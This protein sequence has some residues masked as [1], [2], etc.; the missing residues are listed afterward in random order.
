MP[1]FH[2]ISVPHS[3][4]L[5]KN[6][7]SEVYA[8]KLWDVHNKRGSDEYVDAETFFDKTYITDNMQDILESVKRRLDG[9][10]GGHFRSI[11]TP[12]GG[13]KTH[14][15][16]ALYH[17]C[18][19]W[20]SKPVVIV[21]NELDVRKQ[22]IWGAIEEQLTGKVERLGG[23]IPRGGEV[24]RSVLEEQNKPVLI[25]IDELL[26]YIVKAEG[27]KI[28]ETTLAIQTIAF[29]QELSEAVNSLEN[30]CVV[31][32][33]PSSANEQFDGERYEMLCDMLRKVAGRVRDTISPVADIDIPRIIRRRLFSSTDDE[34]RD[35]AEGIVKGHVN[36]CKDAGLIP[37]NMQPSEYRDAFLAS[38]P[39]LPQVIDVL[40]K[41]WGTLS[42][43]QRTRG[44][45][46]L[47]SLVVGSL[48]D[49]DKQFITLGDFDMSNNAI[50][51]EI[52]EYLSP[53][54][55]GVIAKDVV[56]DGSGAHKVDHKVP[57]QYQGKHLGTRAAAAMFMYSHSG[58]ADIKNGAT[59][60]E[61]KRA[62]CEW[63]IPAA[64]I[65]E[66]LNLFRSNMFYLNV[67][68]GRYMFTKETNMQKHK[69]DIMDNLQ[70]KD[71]EDATKDLLQKNIMRIR[72]ILTIL[73]PTKSSDVEDSKR[74]KLA[75]MREND[76]ELIKIIHDRYGE[77]VRIYRNNIFFL[78]PSDSERTRFMRSLKSKIALEKIK[79]DPQINLKDE[80]SEILKSELDNE[81]AHLESL[82]K[83]YYGVLYIPEENG[84]DRNMMR[85]PPVTNSGI[86]RMVYDQ[87][88][89]GET[90]STNIGPMSLRR[91]YLNDKNVVD[92][93]DLLKSMLSVPGERRPA[94]KD[95]LARAITNGVHT[96]EFGLG[97]VVNGTP[98][99]K[100][101]KEP[102]VVNF[103]HG[104]AII[105]ASLC[106]DNQRKSEKDIKTGIKENDAESPKQ[107]TP[108]PSTIKHH[109]DNNVE[110]L[111][112]GFNVPEGQV[113]HISRMLLSIASHYKDLRLQVS[114]SDGSMSEHDVKMIKETLK[115]MGSEFD[116]LS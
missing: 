105:H 93:S 79:I 101:F 66:V 8:A 81:N 85:P 15:L 113:N 100:F 90:V 6:F 48:A 75:I 76:L 46:R 68:N 116:G 55:N 9:K 19:K 33:L 47:L 92:T 110:Q 83:E 80:Q 115:Q 62:T 74:I 16:I 52:I 86:D 18:D 89:D 58:A 97:E 82:I 73:W 98:V 53:Q 57:E 29:I 87:L 11:T 102:A 56:G 3:D 32:T 106:I 41:R 5:S 44:V 12:F 51:Q 1:A 30:V 35:R 40:Y 24:L 77:S 71:I 27:V 2:Q 37:D 39:F 49:S 14:T 21:G 95:V 64:Q 50:K 20:G 69:A 65:S 31:V 72:D 70:P 10:G 107:H 28:N 104:E 78:A 91:N 60:S 34:I 99:V 103:E 61:I 96:G 43:F 54:F 84:L 109:S 4:I 42:H 114:A 45:L 38:Y 88:T 22:T 7:S 94:N 26:P 13:G 25:L 63:D 17:M 67:V 111:V 108:Q 112:F 59:E 36:Y 23:Q